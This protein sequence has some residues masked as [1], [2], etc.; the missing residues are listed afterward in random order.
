[1]KKGLLL[2]ASVL[3]GAATSY[4]APGDFYLVG[5]EIGW[6][7]NPEYVFTKTGDNTYEFTAPEGK[8]IGGTFAIVASHDNGKGEEINWG[9][10]RSSNGSKLVVGEEYQMWNG[11]DQHGNV[12]I[13]GRL[14]N[15]VFTFNSYSSKVLVTAGVK[16]NEYT[17]VQLIGDF[18]QGWNDNATDRPMA[19]VEGSETLWQGEYTITG[20]KNY[21]K[22]RAG[23]YVYGANGADIECIENTPATG[24]KGGEKTFWLPA[25]SYIFTFDLAKNAES[26]QLTINTVPN[27]APTAAEGTMTYDKDADTYTLTAETL[28]DGIDVSFELPAGA[29]LFVADLFAQEVGSEPLRRVSAAD[30]TDAGMTAVEGNTLRLPVGEGQYSYMVLTAGRVYGPSFLAYNIAQVYDYS[31]VPMVAGT[32]LELNTEIGKYEYYNELDSFTYEV[33]F[34]MP[35]G[36]TLFVKDLSADAGI[37]QEPLALRVLGTAATEMS[38]MTEGYAPVEGNSIQVPFGTREFAFGALKDGKFYAGEGTLYSEV[39]LKVV[40]SV[41]GVALP[42]DE[43]EGV[44]VCNTKLTTAEA[45]AV[46]LNVPEEAVVIYKDVNKE[47]EF[48][49]ELTP[50]ALVAVGYTKA[51]GNVIELPVDEG[52]VEYAVFYQGEQ[53]GAGWIQY[54]VTRDNNTGVA[55]IE[56]AGAAE[57]FNLQGQ[58]ISQ[59]EKGLYIRVINGKAVKVVK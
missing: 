23:S 19:L 41:D 16:E 38:L 25:G 50:E 57:Y 6:G 52:T 15:A 8:T 47:I 3:V 28:A 43:A 45:A 24:V 4:A 9:T 31:I 34:D 44:Y 22:M 13:D 39:A 54:N 7:V 36:A 5:S 51:A 37:S 10:K 17:T 12:N 27:L 32:A 58:K 53:M 40:P 56:A 26:G 42:Y 29:Q 59:P 48:P 11:N 21:F 33:T 30:L 46:T 55:A 35:E 2:F 20:A 49:E 14:E 1:M 18:G